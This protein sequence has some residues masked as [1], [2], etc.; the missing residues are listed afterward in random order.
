MDQSCPFAD[1]ERG[2]SDENLPHIEG[3]FSKLETQVGDLRANQESLARSVDD[4]FNRV[5]A[6][7]KSVAVS[8]DQK[9]TTI[10]SARQAATLPFIS[11]A[12]VVLGMA[13][14]FLYHVLSGQAT[15]INDTRTAL[16]QDIKDVN[17]RLYLSQYERGRADAIQGQTVTEVAKLDVKLQNET[18]LIAD[19]LDERI[20]AL[21]EKL[22][23]ESR[24]VAATTQQQMRD[25]EE[26]AQNMRAWRLTHTEDEAYFRGRT[27][28][29]NASQIQQLRL[30]EGR[31]YDKRPNGK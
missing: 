2:P 3:R 9:V 18:K 26:F 24:L 1:K 27:D 25:F 15:G 21:D 13:A 10:G 7:I 8:V 31:Q 20:K 23:V 22:Q 6:E 28:A 5:F 30:I 11:M 19:R 29:D 17:S 12:L 4:G 16:T 14:G